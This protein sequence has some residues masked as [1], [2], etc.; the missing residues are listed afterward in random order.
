VTRTFDGLTSRWTRPR[1]CAASRAAAICPAIATGLFLRQGAAREQL[2]ELGAVDVAHGDVQLAGDLAGVVDR[3]DVRV[4][5]RGGE[6]G[7]AQEALAEALVLRELGGEDLQR[8]RPLEREVVGAEH[9]SHP[10]AA[11]EGLQPVAGEL[12]AQTGIG[13]HRA[14]GGGV[15]FTQAG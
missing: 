4:V 7:L 3:D 11:D 8:D 15:R 1:A 5:D 10:A 6:A 14:H 9:D 13:P 2:L 12:A